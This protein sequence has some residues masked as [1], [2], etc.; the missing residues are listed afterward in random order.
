MCHV[1]P[2]L[3]GGFCTNR[4]CLGQCSLVCV[5]GVGMMSDQTKVTA[6]PL[7]LTGSEWGAYPC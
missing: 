2:Y 1:S 3:V 4:H 5:A 6:I 7:V